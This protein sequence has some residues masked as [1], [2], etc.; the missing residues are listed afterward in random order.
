MSSAV[1][2]LHWAAA[3][4]IAIAAPAAFGQT[5]YRCTSSTGTQ[6]SD[7][8]CDTSTQTTLKTYGPAPASSATPP[9]HVPMINRGPEI[10]PY[11][12]PECASLNDAI[13]T[14]PA[15][16]LKGQAMSD[17]MLDYRKRCS[18]DEQLAHQKLRQSRSDDRQQRQLAQ[19]AQNAEQA[20]AKLSVEQCSEMLGTLAARRKRAATMT[21]GERNDLDLFEANYKAR[22]KSG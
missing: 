12:S 20:R 15:R 1:A 7:R 14:G 13:R 3:A 18:E 16:G 19:A 9:N 4:L 6:V 22:C 21:P 2:S 10:L 11:L 5:L 8:P 17:L